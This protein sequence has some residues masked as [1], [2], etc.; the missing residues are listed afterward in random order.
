MVVTICDHISSLGLI[1]NNAQN[2]SLV[3]ALSVA[4]CHEHREEDPE[5]KTLRTK[6]S[7]DYSKRH[8]SEKNT[9]QHQKALKL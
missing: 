5:L 6:H 7:K 9:Y 1:S 8:D 2:L 3:T 4:F